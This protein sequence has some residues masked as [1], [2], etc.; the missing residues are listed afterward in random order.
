MPRLLSF[1]ALRIQWSNP[2]VVAFDG[3]RT[4][5]YRS[6]ESPRLFL[7]RPTSKSKAF[8][9]KWPQ[10]QAL[11]PQ[12]MGLSLSKATRAN[13]KGA[14]SNSLGVAQPALFYAYGLQ[15]CASGTSF[16]RQG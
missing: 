15:S 16:Q 10:G 6:A 3:E 5:C 12:P 2:A 1:M 13:P 14:H 11:R 8:P 9:R 7:P 4:A